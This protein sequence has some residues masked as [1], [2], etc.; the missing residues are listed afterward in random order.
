MC[1]TEIG[2]RVKHIL[3]LLM[4]AMIVLDIHVAKATVLETAQTRYQLS[5]IFW[6]N[7]ENKTEKIAASTMRK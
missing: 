3:A 1:I 2:I 5:A 4:V 7:K 6:S